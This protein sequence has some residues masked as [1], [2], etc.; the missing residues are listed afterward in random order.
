MKLYIALVITLVLNMAIWAGCRSSQEYSS[1]VEI[2]RNLFNGKGMCFGCHGK[3]ADG[4]TG[5]EPIAIKIEPLPPNLRDSQSLHYQKN[6][7]IFQ[8]LKE[9]L[10]GPVT[11]EEIWQLVAFLRTIRN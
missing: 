3:N 10:H 4:Q 5:V 1:E 6:E 2:G 9:R 7:D 8:F 11:E